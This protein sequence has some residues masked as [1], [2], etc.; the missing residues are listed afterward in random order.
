MKIFLRI[1][2]LLLFLITGKT[3]ASRQ[4]IIIGTYD[5]YPLSH[6]GVSRK[7][8]L[9]PSIIEKIAHNE[10]WKITYKDDSF[11]KLSDLLHKGEIDILVAAPF[12]QMNSDSVKFNSETVLSTWADIHVR[13][14]NEIQSVLDLENMVLG[15]VRDDPYN[16][17]I[18]NNIKSLNLNCRFVEFKHYS[19]LLKAVE[20]S[21]ID[22]G[23]VDRL[24]SA[25]NS[26]KFDTKKT[27]VIISPV[28]LRFAVNSSKASSLLPAIDYNLRIMKN[29]PDSFYYSAIEKVIGEKNQSELIKKVKYAAFIF[30]GIFL[31]MSV[32]SLVLRNRIKS[33]TA[34]LTEKNK[35]LKEEIARRTNAESALINSNRLLQKTFSSM[36]DGLFIINEKAD[37]III[38]NKAAASLLKYTEEQ[39]SRTVPA[40]L[41]AYPEKWTG[42]LRSVRKEIQE[43]SFYNDEVSLRRKNREV[44]PAEIAVTQI[45]GQESINNCYVV[46]VKDMSVHEALKNSEVR[47]RQSQK[48]ESIGTL[49][50]GIAHDFNNVLTPVIGYAELVIEDFEKDHPDRIYMEYL[51][52]AAYRAKDLVKQILAFSRQE[53]RRFQPV[54][55][56]SIIKE[57]MKMIKAASPPNI[58]VLIDTD[59]PE[60]RVLGDTTGLNQILM[61]ICGNAVHSMQIKGGILEIKLRV[62]EGPVKGWSS[63][64]DLP[65]GKFLRLSIKDTGSGISPENYHRIFDPFFTTKKPGEGTGMGLSVSH[66]II[67]NHSGFISV[68]SSPGRGSCFNI[69]LPVTKAMPA[70]SIP[71][72]S[73]PAL[74][75]NSEKVLF[76]DDEQMIVH[77]TSK[78]LEKSGYQVYAYTD[79]RKALQEFLSAPR[80]YDLIITDHLMPEMNGLEFAEK[81]RNVSNDIPV[82]LCTGFPREEIASSVGTVLSEYVI[83][84]LIGNELMFVI[85]KLIGKSKLQKFEKEST[86]NG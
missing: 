77:M 55:L 82:L 11:K 65:E 57:S 80:F 50:G 37:R 32:L 29:N 63:R 51:L 5:F 67:K 1:F 54:N 25:L 8:C 17:D 30:F 13:P 64:A 70:K 4:E 52:K 83:K 6:R 20:K 79:P 48:M 69:F 74:R 56:S 46:I 12:K 14:E 84:P 22:A 43:R 39:L 38:C 73:V 40:K 68:E 7:D 28:E 34:E 61:N 62:H 3:N 42:F 16:K 23:A 71:T 58:K 72:P 75:G 53:D 2:I 45:S 49:A 18:R 60:D 9:F 76:V 36:L 21:W 85:K 33:R 86:K 66:G 78:M 26:K 44:F 35:S 19:E 31:F 81:I 15:L 41:F 10:G 59:C 24:F 47:L 27:S